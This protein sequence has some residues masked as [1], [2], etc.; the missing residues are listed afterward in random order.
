MEWFGGGSQGQ[1]SRAGCG[2]SMFLRIL[3]QNR[4]FTVYWKTRLGF[5]CRPVRSL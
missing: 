1:M 4:G 5:Q 2:S 3:R